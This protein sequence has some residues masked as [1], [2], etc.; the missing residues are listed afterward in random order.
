MPASVYLDANIFLGFYA[1]S[2]ADLDQLKELERL[3]YEGHF[4]MF[5]PSQ[6]L[7]E[8]V[9]NREKIVAESIEQFGR[10]R[11]SA[12]VPLIMAGLEEVAAFQEAFKET[13]RK[14][15]ELIRVARQRAA[16]RTLHADD[17]IEGLV[18]VSTEIACTDALFFAAMKRHRLG[19]PP[20][21]GSE[22]GDE[23][24]WEA[25]LAACPDGELHVV[26]RDGDYRSAL[27]NTKARSFL[28]DEWGKKKNGSLILH[29][30]V[31]TLLAAFNVQIQLATEAA[32]TDL[33][34][35]LERSGS[36][37]ST[38]RVIAELLPYFRLLSS[39]E[40]ARLVKAALNNSQIGDILQDSDVLDFYSRLIDA[41]SAELATE[42]DVRKMRALLLR[43][44]PAPLAD[45]DDVL[46]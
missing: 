2:D 33:I 31:S 10:D 15:A 40:A 34:E 14:R 24:N 16:E 6:T 21:K 27:D 37:Q 44:A 18:A 4:A 26:S 32:K 20:G 35:R 9:R 1:Y 25:L 30:D 39:T 29:K 22:I 12:K 41:H 17:L 45:N 5:L 28:S 38:H 3:I 13:E 11:P 46:F 42:G 7:D 23:L 19:N 43:Q 36:Y 8:I